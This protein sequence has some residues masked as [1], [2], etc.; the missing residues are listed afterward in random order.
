M[1]SNKKIDYNRDYAGIMIKNA[2]GEFLFQLRDNNP[3]IPNANKWGIFGGG[4]EPGES[5]VQTI[6]RELKEEL[7]L[8][9]VPEKLQLIF[10]KETKK[11]R[12][13][14]F[15]YGLSE[16]IQDLHLMEGQ[17]YSFFRLRKLFFKKNVVFTLR[18]FALLYPFFSL[19]MKA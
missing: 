6:I 16:H 7:N 18:L 11:E 5:A 2:K 15:Y 8:D 10:K 17:A 12:R 13:Y 4:I 9:I 3:H 19:K 1:F 14:V